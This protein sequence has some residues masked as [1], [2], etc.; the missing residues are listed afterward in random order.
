MC[1][2]VMTNLVYA[3]VTKV[4]RV[5]LCHQLMISHLCHF[6]APVRADRLLERYL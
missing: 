1:R 5:V 4:N 3:H 2:C 6:T